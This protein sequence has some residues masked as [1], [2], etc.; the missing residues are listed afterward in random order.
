MQGGRY[1]QW[2]K[3]SLPYKTFWK[4]PWTHMGWVCFH[5]KKFHRP[6]RNLDDLDRHR[7]SSSWRHFLCDN[8]SN[9]EFAAEA[10]WKF[11]FFER[12]KQTSEL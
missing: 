5:K 1:F 2:K 6:W 7:S 3:K 12:E 11:A 9:H 4:Q 10:S 8:K